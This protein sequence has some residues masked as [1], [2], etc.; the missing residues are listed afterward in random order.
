MARITTWRKIFRKFILIVCQI[1]FKLADSY[2]AKGLRAHK[3]SELDKVIIEMIET[4]N[5]VIGRYL[6][7]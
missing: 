2:R 7:R 1:L 6:G 3:A 5:T 4:N